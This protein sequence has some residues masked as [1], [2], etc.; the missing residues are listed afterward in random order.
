MTTQSSIQRITSRAN[1]LVKRLR[2][3]AVQTSVYRNDGQIWLEGDHLCRA[4]LAR[5]QVVSQAFF[6]ESLWEEEVNFGLGVRL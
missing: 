3:G 5:K 2:Q 4:A 1:P 6:A